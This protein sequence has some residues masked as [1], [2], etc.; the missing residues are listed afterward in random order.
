MTTETWLVVAWVAACA[1]AM[2][3]A[4]LVWWYLRRRE[5]STVA[6]LRAMVQHERELRRMA[7]HRLAF[8][9]GLRESS[10][11]TVDWRRDP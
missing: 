1:G 9:V 2:L 11:I 7:E 3:G 4:D 5:A 6:V 10:I 8:W